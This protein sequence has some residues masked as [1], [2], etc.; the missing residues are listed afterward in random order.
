MGI[1][2]ADINNDLLQD[3][4]V[5]DMASSDHVRSKTLMASMNTAKFDF[6]VNKADYHYQYMYNSLQL[7]LG[8][9]QFNNIAQLTSM[10]NTDWSW[11]VLMSDYD[12][13]ADK[14]IYITNGYRKYALD[15]DDTQNKVYAA[16]VKYK[17]QVP[18]QIKQQLYDAIPSEKTIQYSV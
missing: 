16:K 7:N 1:D 6:L 11:S 15:N 14:D 8:N 17:N 2:V 4:F 3:I 13:D 10:A 5:L 18:S 12:L 9:N